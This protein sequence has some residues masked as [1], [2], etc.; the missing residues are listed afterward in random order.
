MGHAASWPWAYACTRK[1]AWEKRESIKNSGAQALLCG[2]ELPKGKVRF[3]KMAV[4]SI[5]DYSNLQKPNSRT[6]SPRET[7]K[8]SIKSTVHQFT[9]SGP[10]ANSLTSSTPCSLPQRPPH[11]EEA[12]CLS[13]FVHNPLSHL[14]AF[15]LHSSLLFSSVFHPKDLCATPPVAELPL[16]ASPQDSRAVLASWIGSTQ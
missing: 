8:A 13:S 15:W 12:F 6:S 9:E 3:D 16:Y 1:Y 7:F 11:P 2:M 4:V 5:M 14:T 10:S